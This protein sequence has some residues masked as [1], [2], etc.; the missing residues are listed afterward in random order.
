MPDENSLSLSVGTGINT[1]THFKDFS[2]LQSSST[3]WLGFDR[4][5]RPLSKDFP[6]HL[7][8]MT[9]PSQ[10]TYYT[11][12]GFNNDWNVKTFRPLPDLKLNLTWNRKI[13]D[14]V[15]TV[16]TFGYSN[17]N[18]TIPDMQ[19]TRYGIYS[20]TADVPTIEK[21]YID[22]QF[23]NE[24]K[25]NAMNNWSFI[26]DS[27]NRFEFRNLFSQIGKNRFTERYGTSTVSG[28]YYENQ[29]EMLY[30]SRLSYVGQL[31]G[32]H[33]LDEDMTQTLNWTVDY[34]YANKMEPDRRIIKNIGGIPADK[35]ITPDLP[36]YNDM[37]NRYD[38]KLYD[39]IA[40]VGA[41]YKKSFSDRSWNP[42]I[43]SGIYG[44]YRIR[45][46]TPREF[47]Y[48]YDRLSGDERVDYINL[49]YTEMMNE[50]WL[51]YDKVYIEE[52]TRKSNAY[53][54]KN[55]IAAAYVEG[56]FPFGAFQVNLGVRAEWWNMSIKYDRAISASQILMTEYKYDKVSVLPS[57]NATYSFNDKNL[58]RLAYGRSV[59]RPEFR[60]VSPA[61]YYDFELFAEVQGNPDLKMATIDNVDLRYELYPSA[62]ETVSVGLFYKNFRNPIEWNFIDMGGSYRYSYENARSAYTTGVEVDIRKSLDFINIPDLT[63]VLNAAWVKS[64][65]KFSDEGL[66]KEKDRPLQGQSPY[67]VN[68]GLYYTSSEKIGL[69]ASLLYNIIG[70]RIV[71]VG[72]STSVDGNSDYDVPDA[73][74]MPRNVLDLTINKTF[75]K[76]VSL[77]LGIKDILAQSVIMKQFPTTTID[78]VKQ[79]REQITRKYTPGRSISL[80]L[81]LKF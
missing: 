38:Q 24:L 81:S 20:A 77:K 67:I 40:S 45:E 36:S 32:L 47:I 68:A 7:G 66:V 79:E 43:K 14:K 25:I 56:V 12:T 64:R 1:V 59:N 75:G 55:S 44:E 52:T 62:G 34:S 8:S 61:V 74:E 80:S 28:E 50:K 37:I 2:L 49:P 27:K 31:A 71:G 58:I 54:G 16:L 3:E 33:T 4:C 23:T 22:N 29:T 72:K 69:S 17:A 73:Y 42:E 78:G 18:K 53:D 15:G 9:D 6:S 5:A 35:V 11:K 76:I 26:L 13:G 19:N 39:H 21:N 60:E 30:S 63:L 46:Y 51:G 70:K 65:V 10:I 41:D 48:R 57:F